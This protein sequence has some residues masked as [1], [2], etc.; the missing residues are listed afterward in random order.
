MRDFLRNTA[1]ILDNMRRNSQFVGR[2]MFF[3]EEESHVHNFGEL[4]IDRQCHFTFRFSASNK[5]NHSVTYTSPRG[6]EE[7]S[8]FDFNP[9]HQ[10]SITTELYGRRAKGMVPKHF[11]QPA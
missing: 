4:W 9:M 10:K 2:L 1:D 3:R 11:R 8:D 7:P 6:K 5:R